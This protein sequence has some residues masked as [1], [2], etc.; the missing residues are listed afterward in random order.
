[1]DLRSGDFFS[2][3]IDAAPDGLLIVDSQGVIRVA[4]RQASELFGVPPDGLVGAPVDSLPSSRS[5][6]A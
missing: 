5:R 1:M 4:N 2:A 6:S 3:V